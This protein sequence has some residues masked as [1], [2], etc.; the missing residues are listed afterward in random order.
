MPVSSVSG[1]VTNL[2]LVSCGFDST[3]I[4]LLLGKDVKLF[5]F[6]LVLRILTMKIH[7]QE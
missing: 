1:S 4:G 7:R 5:V 2:L 6:S 3:E